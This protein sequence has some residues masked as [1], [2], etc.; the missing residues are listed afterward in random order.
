MRI[1]HIHGPSGSGKTRNA[2]ALAQHYR[3]KHV[4]DEGEYT[5]AG[6]QQAARDGGVLVLSTKATTKA[7]SVPIKDAL[8]AAGIFLYRSE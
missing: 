6:L 2:K 5:E 8:R 4:V 3:C 7:I 1:V